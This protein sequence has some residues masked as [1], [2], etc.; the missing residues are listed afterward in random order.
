M[1]YSNLLLAFFSIATVSAQIN[2]GDSLAHLEILHEENFPRPPFVMYFEK[3]KPEMNPL[4]N[5]PY[6]SALS[7]KT[8]IFY[9][10][11]AQN[12]QEPLAFS[13]TYAVVI[14]DSYEGLC[15]EIGVDALPTTLIIGENYVV[16]KVLTGSADNSCFDMESVAS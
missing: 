7:V 12:A 14:Y 4:N 11:V 16:K 8:P 3:E 15:A 9:V 1:R 2:I 10:A 6:L 13:T 5:H